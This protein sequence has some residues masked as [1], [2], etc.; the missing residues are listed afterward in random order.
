MTTAAEA[1]K[2]L[3]ISSM[4]ARSSS[5]SRHLPLDQSFA[6]IQGTIGQ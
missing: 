6:K 4:Q 3:P 2:S 5:F 1:V